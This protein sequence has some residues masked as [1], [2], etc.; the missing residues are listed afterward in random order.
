MYLRRLLNLYE[1]N[2]FW[3]LF[4]I[5]GIFSAIFITYS[6]V[7]HLNFQTNAFD[8]GIYTQITYLYSHG[9]TPFSTI[10]NMPLLADHFEPVLWIIAPLYRLFPSP[11][12]L[13]IIQAL[14]VGLSSL[15]LYVTALKITKSKTLSLLLILSYLTSIGII[16]A[17]KFDFHTTALAV[18][19][20]SLL[21]YTWHWK[22]WKLYWLSL[23]F[24]FLIKEDVSLLT[25][26][27]GIYQI[28]TGQKRIGLITTLLSLAVFI[29][30]KFII[31][32]FIWKGSDQGYIST[33]ILPL[34]SPVDLIFLLFTNPKIVLDV[35][36]NSPIKQETFFEL[37]KPFGLLPL[38]SP[39]SWLTAFPQLFFR[40]SSTQT[41]FWSTLFHYNANIMPFLMISAALAINRW[42]LPVKP[43]ALLILILVAF[44]SLSPNSMVWESFQM[45][46]KTDSQLKANSIQLIP[47]QESVSAQSPLVPHL[48]NRSHIYLFPDVSIANYIVLDLSLESYPIEKKDITRIISELENSKYWKVYEKSGTTIIFERV[49]KI[50][51]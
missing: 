10:K 40:F 15:P 47:K 7:K 8:L 5:T 46:V 39:L 45:R 9:L 2:H 36:F 50:K 38:L 43:I 29:T 37:Y 18:L 12:T 11:S 49:E 1:K 33:S 26:G 44:S 19:P 24:G 16:N 51:N 14:F 30:T 17:I 6:Q 41:H 13:L 42:S 3:I 32:P 21:V 22:K 31:M 27:L 34:T 25:V 28:I 20:I 4:A 23:M 48:A 35:F